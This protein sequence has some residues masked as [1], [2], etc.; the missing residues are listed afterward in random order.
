MIYHR[1]YRSYNDY[2]YMQ[3]YKARNHKEYLLSSNNKREKDFIMYFERFRKYMADG[4]IL[5]LGARTGCEVR[6]AIKYGFHNSFG[7]DIHPL[8]GSVI[9]ADWH[10]LPFGDSTFE[11][12]FTNSLDHCLY[13]MRLASEIKRVLVPFGVF[14]FETHSNYAFD[15]RIP[16]DEVNNLELH[17]RHPLNSMFWDSIDDVIK[18][19]IELGFVLLHK[20]VGKKTSSVFLL[21]KGK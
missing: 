18:V 15:S 14:V 3:G 5:C 19:F 17:N 21:K 2:I 13:F 4:K 12:I 16:G 6:A 10:Y 11:N 1:R 20:E 9:K 7:I 8:C